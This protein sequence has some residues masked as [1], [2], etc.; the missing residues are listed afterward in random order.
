VT[1]RTV[2]F[3][4]IVSHALLLMLCVC[5]TPLSTALGVPWVGYSW[6]DWH[7]FVLPHVVVVGVL[8][9]LHAAS[10][11][12]SA[13]GRISR[14]AA[15]WSQASVIAT[16]IWA[17]ALWPRGDDGG[18]MSWLLFV[19]PLTMVPV[20]VTATV[21]AATGHPVDGRASQASPPLPVRTWQAAV[22][23]AVLA[24]L[25]GG[26]VNGFA[27][28]ISSDLRHTMAL[29]EIKRREAMYGFASGPLPK[30]RT[31]SCLSRGR[32]GDGWGIVALDPGSPL[33]KA[34]LHV[35]DALVGLEGDDY[36]MPHELSEL[37][38]GRAATFV[39]VACGQDGNREEREVRVSNADRERDTREGR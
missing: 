1:Q 10:V 35:G 19:N 23:T 25:L 21:W 22:A 15:G 37:D 33:A 11:M 29:R 28:A 8:L 7:P 38:A 24:V 18:G 26:V 20:I 4:L 2:W 12:D 16:Y 36:L 27:G 30:E 9:L 31:M 3:A 5:F 6:T 34:G 14:L 17:M 39:V 32:F 13:V